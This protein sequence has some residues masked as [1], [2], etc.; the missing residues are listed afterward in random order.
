MVRS[1][2]S[3][4]H[5]SRDEVTLAQV[6]QFKLNMVLE[7]L[8]C[9]HKRLMNADELMQTWPPRSTMRQIARKARC[10]NRGCRGRSGAEV[11]FCLG[12]HKNDWWPRVPLI[13]R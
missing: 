6:K 13:R 10:T 7:C 8:G 11:L 3:G 12:D 4:V 5:G 2:P 1:S 9:G